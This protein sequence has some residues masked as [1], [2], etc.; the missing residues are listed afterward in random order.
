MKKKS[1]NIMG[2]LLIPALLG[3]F[4]QAAGANPEGGLLP[5]DQRPPEVEGGSLGLELPPG[6]TFGLNLPPED[7][8]LLKILW[9]VL[10]QNIEDDI[11]FEIETKIKPLLGVPEAAKRLKEESS[12]GNFLDLCR[13]GTLRR[14]QNA[15][16]AGANV[17]A[18]H[19][20]RYSGFDATG[21][22]PLM[23][24]AK[25]NANPA[26]VVALLV[27]N[28]ADVNAKS[29]RGM[30]PLI[31]AVERITN[32]NVIMALIKNGA[33]VN[34]SSAGAQFVAAARNSNPEIIT[35]LL[36]NGAYVNAKWDVN[37][38][39]ALML[40]AGYNSNPEV[41][42]A[43]IKNGADVNQKNG[44]HGNGDTALMFA[45]MGN[46]NPEVFT[47]LLKNGADFEAA[48]G[49]WKVL[50]AAM[51]P[52]A[53][54]YSTVDARTRKPEVNA[55]L[56]T[57]LVKNGLDV[58][59]RSSDGQTAL[60]GEVWNE[61]RI[62]VIEALIRNGADVNASDSGGW[63]ALMQAAGSRENLEAVT[64]LLKNGADVKM[65][66]KRGKTALDYAESSRNYS[67][68]KLLESHGLK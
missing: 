17:N 42:T 40:A 43:L 7:I 20:G 60:M 64:L 23:F 4:A 25:Y 27:Y 35:A 39:T 53:I 51:D 24:A 49:M 21:W 37:G 55:A 16:D 65:K 32:I 34:A 47:T 31:A 19:K 13:K 22:T 44:A 8:D 10:K 14:I 28:G 15:I 38:K 5:S 1:L 48:G 36:K 57:A 58:N 2:G 68:L 61:G 56:I 9:Q 59:A 46:D 45:A 41:I 30:T 26:E 63:T 54:S 11:K 29:A 52:H 50:K 33:D 67:T 6:T 3:L 62:E 18:E 12:D 66:D